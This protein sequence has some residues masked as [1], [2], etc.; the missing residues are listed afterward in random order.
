MVEPPGFSTI[1]ADIFVISQG[2]SDIKATFQRTNYG[3]CSARNCV[4]LLQILAEKRQQYFAVPIK[5]ISFIG[6]ARSSVETAFY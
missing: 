2:K 5:L 1:I 6:G 4:T 3:V